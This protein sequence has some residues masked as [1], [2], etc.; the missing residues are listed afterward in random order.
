MNIVWLD[1]KAYIRQLNKHRVFT[2]VVLLMLTLG[3]G[4]DALM[5]SV[6]YSVLLRPLPYPHGDRLVQ[7]N[8]VSPSGEP[9]SVSWLNFK[10]W[11]AQSKSLT[12]LSAYLVQSSSLKVSDGD[13]TRVLAVNATTNFFNLLG[14][15][16]ML[17]RTFTSDEDQPNKPCVAVLSE[18]LW[19]KNFAADSAVAGKAIRLDNEPCTVIGVMPKG[20]SFP[21][22]NDGGLWLPLH[23]TI[24]SRGTGYLSVIGRLNPGETLARG[25]SDMELIAQRLSDSYPTENKGMGAKITFYRD[26]VTG[27]VSTA[28]FA[29][30]GAVVLVQ[31]IICA[32][33]GNMQLARAIGRKREMAIRIALGAG[34]WRIARQLFTESFAL[35]LV[36]SAVGLMI[37]HESLNLLKKLAA[38]VLPRINEIQLYPQVV[39]ALVV[40]AGL[41]AVLFGLVPLFQTSEEDLES[42]LRENGRGVNGGRRRTWMRDVLVVGQLSLAVILLF[43][44]VVLLHSLYRL[45]Q[46]DAGFSS[47][48]VLT[49]RTSIAGEIYDGR[50][51]AST[52]YYP[53]LD[54]IRQLPGVE[55]AGFVTFLPL[56]LGHTTAVFNIVGQA[57]GN[58]QYPP[59]AALN[60]ASEDYFRTLR[61]P[62]IRGRFFSQSDGPEAA[63]VAIINDALAQRYFRGQDPIGRQISFGDP[64]YIAHPLTIVGVVHGSRQQTL[65]EPPEPEIYFALHQVPPSSLWTQ[66]LL[67]NVMS[68]VVRTQGASPES[69]VG[70]VR[71]AINSVDSSETLFDIQ[72]MDNVVA[73]FVQDRRLGLILLGIFAALALIV[74]VLGLYAMLSYNVQQRRPEIAVRMAMGA[75]RVDVLQLIAGR[76]FRLTII[77]LTIGIVGAILGSQIISRLL[78][79]VKSWDPITLL[80]TC[81]ILVLITVPAALL[82]AF[83]AASV[84]MLQALRTE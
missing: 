82:P 32:N 71:S 45:L 70:E 56:S 12:D 74:A 61:I 28:L 59:K 20:F 43:G 5:F 33:V 16:P 44:S 9:T 68:Y 73:Q 31:L 34:K 10:D 60:A 19:R 49:M 26:V 36:G 84:N 38:N 21:V 80:A 47:Q 1:L 53:Q 2:M 13:N 24:T 40:T 81:A 51:L 39:L 77:G 66:I 17:G 76:A 55:S 46:Q 22:G 72:T 67:R 58:P 62:L 25:K 7:L 50:N 3:A 29:L 65:A 54:R 69:L 15:S 52:Q 37:A 35:A 8:S 83:R 42:T 11:Q 30:I 63:R 18:T 78:Y 4:A 23:P 75:R 41:T 6:A 64:D 14:V 48:G 27:N 57:N 79:G